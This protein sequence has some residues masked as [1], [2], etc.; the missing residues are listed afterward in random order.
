MTG[1]ATKHAVTSLERLREIIESPGDDA[2][3]VR[4]QLPVLD[5]RCLNFIAKSPFL[6]LA[7]ACGDGR[8][9]VSPR[10]DGPGFVLV[11][12]KRTLMIP[13]RRG[14][15]RLDSLQNIIESP[16]TGF[17]FFVPNVEETLRVDGRA[18]L[19]EAP[20]RLARMEMQGKTPQVGIV[21][22]D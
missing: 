7:T 19:S 16:H 2:P 6:L 4:K 9:D 22:E 1:T 12:D 17:C 21:V 14:N 10:G 13:D 20:E 11:L 8:C 5:G 15:L 3:A 18:W